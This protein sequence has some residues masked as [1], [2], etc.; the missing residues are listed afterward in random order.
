ML[1]FMSFSLVPISSAAGYL[2]QQLHT[3]PYVDIS[4]LIVDTGAVHIVKTTENIILSNNLP[5]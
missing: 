2:Y 4:L 1:F 5:L 3:L